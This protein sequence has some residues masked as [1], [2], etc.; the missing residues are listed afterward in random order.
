MR[1]LR[2]QTHGALLIYRS[3]NASYQLSAEAHRMMLMQ[4]N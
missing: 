2:K 3:G 4:P 1:V